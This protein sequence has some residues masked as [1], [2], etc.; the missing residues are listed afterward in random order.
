M[1]FLNLSAVLPEIFLLV[2]ACALLMVDAARSGRFGPIIHRLGLVGLFVSMGAVVWQFGRPVQWAFQGMYVTDQLAQVLKLVSGLAVAA[3]LVYGRAYCADRGMARAEFYA[4]ALFSL[5]GQWVMMSAGHL[6]V[7]YL[8]LEMMTLALYGLAALR[9]DDSVASEA[10]M[11]YFV[12]GALASGFLLYGMSM[13]YGGTGTLDLALMAQL[14]ASPG[15][16][17]NP[18][19]AMLG[20]VFLVAGLAFKFGAVPFHMWVPDVYQGTP[21]VAT[22][23]IAAAPKLATFAMAYRL[24]AEGLLGLASEWQD[25]LMILAV[26]SLVLGNLVAI[27]QTDLKRMVAYSAIAQIGFALLG[28]VS[29]VVSG[30]VQG[31]AGPWAAAMFYLVAYVVTTVAGLGVLLL[32]AVPGAE[33]QGIDDLKG[34]ARRSPGL[35]LVMLV[36]MFSLAGIPP[37][38]GFQAKLAVLQTVVDAGRVWLAVLAVLVS[39]AAAFYYLRVVKV[40]YFDEPVET[41]VLVSATDARAVLAVNGALVVVL[42]LIP[43]QLMVVCIEAV[44]QALSI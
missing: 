43:G 19:V 26:F 29:G 44:R 17:V 24:L 34:L 9:R 36:V 5:L 14:L 3:T 18:T 40:M 42:G 15:D 37:T 7:V 12:L 2:A 23:L 20:L 21:T 32:I 27:A 11:K 38:V 31:V 6:L 33:R 4:L 39:V 35:A 10:A 1:S 41:S 30:D 25:M 8:G 22:I 16:L 13:L 28:M